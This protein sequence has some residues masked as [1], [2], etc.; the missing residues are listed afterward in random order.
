MARP[1]P[2][3]RRVLEA[4]FGI[5]TDQL[6]TRTKAS[7]ERE[8]APS[9]RNGMVPDRSI[10]DDEHAAPAL[11]EEVSP[12]RRRDL[13]SVSVLFTAGAAFSPAERAA[14]I[15]RAIAAT[16]PDPLG[17][18]QLQHG[19][20]QL[21]T[22]YAVTPHGD[23]VEPVERAW[24]D[25]E[26]LLGA[27]RPGAV[28][29][30]LEL[31]A[32]QYSYYRGQRAFDMGDDATALTFI[33]LA[34]QHADAAGDTLLT[35]SVAI[36]R[37]AVS[38]FSGDFTRAVLI[39]RQAQA[40][41]H[42]YIVPKLASGQAR[43]LAQ[44]GDADGALAALRLMRDNLWTGPPL[45]G[46]ET[47]DEEDYEAFTAVT[48]GFLG[49]GDEAERH[50]RNS[51][52]FLDSTGRHV[53]IAGTQLALARASSAAHAPSRS[54]PRPPCVPRARPPRTRSTA[55]RSTEPRASTD[56]SP[57]TPTGRN[58][59]PSETSE[60]G[61]PSAKHWLRARVGC[62]KSPFH[63]WASELSSRRGS[64]GVI[65]NPGVLRRPA[66]SCGTGRVR[67]DRTVTGPR[68]T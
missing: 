35:G 28:R 49:R 16:G 18:A 4:M 1:Y 20:H 7:Q 9:A 37:A 64:G 52:A 15:S 68:T 11:I 62:R 14:R 30:D 24:E 46:P 12:T 23:L 51:L 50:A 22:G 8:T 38:F 6:L 26:I 63:E 44:L 27:C 47:G 48:L 21:T 57:R 29:R 66:A 58:S 59:Q 25:A 45:P 2:V 43:A 36:M 54:R 61:Y 60:T 39:T 13:L 5:D 32:G 3:A 56:T 33:V 41:A 55:R 42:P 53:Q 10:S 65:D 31:V 34:A 19:I 17:L 67:R 40:G